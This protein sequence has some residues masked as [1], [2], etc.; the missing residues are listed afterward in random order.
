M[1]AVAAVLGFRVQTRRVAMVSAVL[2]AVAKAQAGT[3]HPSLGPGGW[4][5]LVAWCL[6]PRDDGEL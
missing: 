1:W 3:D 5:D 2:V 6:G 4:G